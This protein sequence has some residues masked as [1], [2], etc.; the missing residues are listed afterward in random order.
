MCFILKWREAKEMLYFLWKTDCPFW[1]PKKIYKKILFR[2]FFWAIDI[3]SKKKLFGNLKKNIN[4]ESHFKFLK[5][6]TLPSTRRQFCHKKIEL[7]KIFVIY[8]NVSN[9]ERR[10]NELNHSTLPLTGAGWD[11][12]AGSWPAPCAHRP[13]PLQLSI[14]ALERSGPLRTQGDDINFIQ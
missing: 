7:I 5:M 6:N 9:L 3:W 1:R 10:W 4:F 2:I 13:H 11:I 8:S 14:Q 12:L